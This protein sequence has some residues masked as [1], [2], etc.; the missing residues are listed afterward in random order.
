MASGDVVI[1]NDQMLTINLCG[2][3]RRR[4]DTNVKSASVTSRNAY[5]QNRRRHHFLSTRKVSSM[6]EY[7]R[8]TAT[9]SVAAA[10]SDAGR[11]RQ[12]S[13]DGQLVYVSWL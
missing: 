9:T 10:E 1:V 13:A 7:R 11:L 4:P 5:L 6:V 2:R 3:R 8:A 12:L